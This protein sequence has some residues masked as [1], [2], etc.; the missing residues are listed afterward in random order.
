MMDWLNKLRYDFTDLPLG[1]K[2]KI[3]LHLKEI[4]NGYTH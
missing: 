3:K 4:N 1:E 2:K